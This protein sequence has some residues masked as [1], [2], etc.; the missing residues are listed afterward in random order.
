L[1]RKKIE[2]TLTNS[3]KKS[4]FPTKPF[5]PMIHNII[6]HEGIP[7]HQLT[8]IVVEDEYLRKLHRQ[9]LHKNIYTDVMTFRLE[10]KGQIEAEIY[11]SLDRAKIH[12]QQYHVKLKDEFARLIIHGLLHLKGLDDHTETQRNQMKIQED[13]LLKKYWY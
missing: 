10:D 9:Y 3:Y 2:V 11:I 8:V 5:R 12:A 6:F 7:V 4:V 13:Q 1:V